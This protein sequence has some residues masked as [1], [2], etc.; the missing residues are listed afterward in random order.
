[1]FGEF[2]SDGIQ[3]MTNGIWVW[4][5]VVVGQFL[6]I[7]SSTFPKIPSEVIKSF[8]A[9]IVEHEAGKFL[10]ILEALFELVYFS[11]DVEKVLKSF[12]NGGVGDSEFEKDVSFL[13]V[14]G[15]VMEFEVVDGENVIGDE[16][17]DKSEHFGL[18]EKLRAN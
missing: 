3:G 12:F 7:I 4:G 9:Q 17:V 6:L 14:G 5:N 10:E 15:S 8:F 16:I 11:F 1:M 2:D 13:E 18:N